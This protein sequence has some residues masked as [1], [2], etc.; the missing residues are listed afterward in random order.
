[1]NRFIHNIIILAG[2]ALMLMT[3]GALHASDCL[4]INGES[5]SKNSNT[6]PFV[7]FQHDT[8]NE[9][10]GIEKCDRC[11][12]LYDEQEKLLDGQ[13][14]EEQSCSEC[15]AGEKNSDAL[16]ISLIAK[17]HKLC[18]DCHLDEKKGPVVC[19]ECHKR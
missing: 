6:R 13:S 16:D 17:Y 2:I 14:S 12:H 5:D 10:A 7:C 1:M 15:H 8:H 3:T 4:D 9:T 18:R 19:G 11:H